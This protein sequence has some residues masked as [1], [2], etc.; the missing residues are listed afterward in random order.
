MIFTSFCMTSV[1][2]VLDCLD[3]KFVENRLQDNRVA[4]EARC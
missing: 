2:I 1:G 3:M 4:L